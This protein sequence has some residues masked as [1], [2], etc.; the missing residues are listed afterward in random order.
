MK[1]NFRLLALL[2]LAGALSFAERVAAESGWS[3]TGSLNVARYGH[4]ATRLNDGKVLVA[5]GVDASAELFDPATGTWTLTGSFSAPRAGHEAVLLA[6][7]RVLA[8]G[9]WVGVDA[10]SSSSSAEIYD[11]DSGTWAPTGSM[12]V[13]RGLH[14][15][16]ALTDGTVLVVGGGDGLGLL[17]TAEI[18]DP[19]TGLWSPTGSLNRGRYAHS[20]TLLANGEVLVL[21]GSDSDDD[22]MIPLASAERYDPVLRTWI[23]VPNTNAGGIFHTATLLPSGDV[24]VAGLYSWPALDYSGAKVFDPRV[25]TWSATASLGFA[26]EGHTA[27]LLPSGDVLVAGGHVW[28]HSPTRAIVA[29]GVS[30]LFEARSAT[31]KLAGR[32]NIPRSGHTATLLHDGRVLIA[33]GSELVGLPETGWIWRMVE[34]AEVYGELEG[35]ECPNHYILRHILRRPC[36]GPDEPGL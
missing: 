21:E 34:S 4:S 12:G 20:A 22:W 9:G 33:G 19:A 30:E 29:S 10:R 23:V 6:D 32:L 14:T 7:G 27:T 28:K 16:T 5:G 8:V 36:T 3:V 25:A 15:A 26:R 35:E 1:P 31:W 18:Y 24:L 13:A 17:G 2:L 11:P